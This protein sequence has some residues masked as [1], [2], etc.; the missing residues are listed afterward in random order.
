MEEQKKRDIRDIVAENI[1]RLIKE[2]PG[3]TQT[4]LA[5][6]LGARQ[7]N[8]SRKISVHAKDSF[9]LDQLQEAA[10]YFGVSVRDLVTDTKNRTMPNTL[11]AAAKALFDADSVLNFDI[12]T[13]EGRPVLRPKFNGLDSYIIALS[14]MKQVS[15]TGAGS[16]SALMD[17]FLDTVTEELKE[18]KT[19]LYSYTGIQRQRRRCID[20]L[21]NI[22]Q[23]CYKDVDR[24]M[25]K[26][27]ET[28]EADLNSAANEADQIISHGLRIIR[29][30]FPPEDIAGISIYLDYAAQK[31]GA[32]FAEE[33]LKEIPENDLP[34]EISGQEPKFVIQWLRKWIDRISKETR[35]AAR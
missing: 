34:G 14:S 8:I 13:E 24:N 33:V 23:Q 26:Y 22:I 28:P 12:Q 6:A 27:A 18:K 31:D 19:D 11:A 29:T 20:L 3:A 30:F 32:V 7:P 21:Q 17:K 4:S 25:Q 9:S 16:E 35:K 5:E 15:E 2:T 10:D 1:R